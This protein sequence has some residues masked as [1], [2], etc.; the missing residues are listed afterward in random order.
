MREELGG[1]VED[2][3][4]K[5]DAARLEYQDSLQALAADFGQKLTI[6]ER[7][8]NQTRQNDAD[9]KAGETS[10]G[11]APDDKEVFTLNTSSFDEFE[12]CLES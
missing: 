5:L 10:S 7:K 12:D 3:K 11:V 1:Q 4:H 2:L 8:Y 6:A 9:Q